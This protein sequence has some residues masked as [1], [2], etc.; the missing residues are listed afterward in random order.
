MVGIGRGKLAALLVGT[1]LL[2]AVGAK[3]ALVA[4]DPVKV[5]LSGAAPSK[6]IT[7]RNNG[8]EKVRF[9]VSAFG[10]QQSLGG[11]MQ[12]NPTSELV[13]FPSLLELAPGETRRLRVTSSAQ[14]GSVEK[15]YRLFVDELP[16]Q[17]SSQGGAIRVLTRFGLPVF[18]APDAPKAAPAL[19]LELRDGKLSARLENRGTAHF[20]AQTVRI[21]GRAKDGSSVLQEDLQAWYVLAGGTR[22]FE[23]SPN[24]EICNKLSQLSASANTDHGSAR[25]DYQVPDGACQKP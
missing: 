24:A 15:S 11:E 10:W 22:L 7:L 13:F 12:L 17:T 20:V 4:I 1:L 8:S 19:R 21:V 16:P 14:P 5:L 25:T 18:L 3:A 6:S 9:Q 2:V 23:L